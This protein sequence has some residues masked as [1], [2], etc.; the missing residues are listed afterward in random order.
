MPKLIKD[1]DDDRLKTLLEYLRE[2]N[3]NTKHC[4]V[5]SAVLA[6]LLTAVPATR[7]IKLPNIRD[8]LEGENRMHPRA[9]LAEDAV[10]R[11]P[12]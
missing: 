1:M 6:A 5:S 10:S 11:F 7:I 8:L 9:P 4:H 12:F 3:T 2:W